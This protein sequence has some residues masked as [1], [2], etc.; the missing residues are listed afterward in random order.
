[1]L[2]SGGCHCCPVVINAC[3]LSSC[4]LDS[5]S[6]NAGAEP[7]SKP[8]TKRTRKPTKRPQ[9]MKTKRPHTMKTSQPVIY[10]DTGM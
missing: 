5:E 8:P 1:V 6:A 10:L 2:R 7:I 9:T 4:S 3:P